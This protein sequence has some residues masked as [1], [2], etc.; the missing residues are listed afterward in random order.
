MQVLEIRACTSSGCAGRG[1]GLPQ[2]I[3]IK[4]A[5]TWEGIIQGCVGRSQETVP[6]N[7]SSNLLFLNLNHTLI[8]SARPKLYLALKSI[9]HMTKQTLTKIS[10]SSKGHIGTHCNILLPFECL[11]I[12][13]IKQEKSIPQFPSHLCSLLSYYQFSEDFLSSS[14]LFVLIMYTTHLVSNNMPFLTLMIV[15]V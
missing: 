2:S 12:F 7:L 11:N 4:P 3:Q 10:G 13:I 5:T 9:L 14:L 8:F 6:Q 1:G 15:N